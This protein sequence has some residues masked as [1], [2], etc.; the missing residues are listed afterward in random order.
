MKLTKYILLI[1]ALF[2]LAACGDDEVLSPDNGSNKENESLGTYT[3]QLRFPEV[4]QASSRAWGEPPAYKNLHL[5][6]AVFTGDATSA[7]AANFLTELVQATPGAVVGDVVPYSVT[8]SKTDAPRVVHLIATE[9]ESLD[10]PFG[11]ENVVIPSLTTTGGQDAYWQRVVIPCAINEEN[12]TTVANALGA[13]TPV[14]MLR[15]FAKVSVE[16][17]ENVQGFELTGFAVI[18]TL[19]RGS[20]A[21]WSVAKGFANFLGSDNRML[22]YDQ[23]E[24]AGTLPSGWQLQNDAP[25][26]ATF[27]TADKYFYE[28]PFTSV[29]RTYVIIRGRY[30]NST[31]T[32]YKLD[33]GST[34]TETGL[35]TYYNLLRNFDY[36]ILITSVGAAGEAT[37]QAAA[38]GTVFNNFSASVETRNMLNI[39]DGRD[40]MYVNFTRYVLVSGTEPIELRYR[41]LENIT[42]GLGTVNNEIVNTTQIVPGE[43]IQS[44]NVH[45]TD[46]A[47]G[48]R[49][50]T[51]TPKAPTDV[52]AEQAVTIFKPKGLSRTIT[53]I[54]RNPWS[55]SNIQV[56][57]GTD[58]T[59]PDR[60][61]QPIAP[62]IGAE[63]TIFFDLP[64]ALPEAMFPLEFKLES[65][66]QNVENNP[67]GTLVVSTGPSMFEGVTDNRISYIKTISWAEYDEENG[68]SRTVR[69][70]LLCTTDLAALGVS[71]THTTVLIDNPYFVR[72]QAE[73]DRYR[74]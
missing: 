73:F 24:Y 70:R 62:G 55:I 50:I 21:P 32:Y 4:Q 31:D 51:I 11:P 16:V 30:G 60:E 15:N 41:Y 20:I 47:D 74:N 43:V 19:D 36:H 44:A 52:V 67:I 28:R 42:D 71:E 7:S 27:D 26:T 3:F 65:N 59:R 23:V 1:T 34:D 69:C 25:S 66:R 49:T 45:T 6:L 35:F 22:P 53:F 5:F 12:R 33:L 39:S 13:T 37:P 58:D 64:P 56:F 2:A 46:D 29:N 38:D 61:P 9:A 40:M 54:A 72:N 10:I 18:N 63:L 17:A 48:W 57:N 8:L 14:P 68:G